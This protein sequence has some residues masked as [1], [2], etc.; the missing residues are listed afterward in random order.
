MKAP[1]AVRLAA[2]LVTPLLASTS[3]CGCGFDCNNG[4]NNN[5]SPALLSLGLSDSLPEDLKQ[6]VIEVDSITLQRSGAADVVIEQFTIDD[7]NGPASDTFQVDL[8]DYQG[9]NQLIVISDLELD[10][11][12]YSGISIAIVDEDINNSFVQEADDSIKILSAT[13]SAI[14]APGMT[15]DSGTQQFTVEFGLAQSLQYRSGD[16]SY[17][18]TNNGVR[19]EDN[20]VAASLS[21]RVDRDLFDSVSPCDEKTDPESGNRVYLYQGQGLTDGQLGDVFNSGSS[22]EVP[23]NTIAPFAVASMA[24][25]A[26]TGIWQYAFGFLPA[27]DYTLAFSCDTADDDSTDFDDLTIA[28]PTGQVYEISLGEAETAVC[29]LTTDA[30]CS[31]Q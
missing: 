4:N 29:D 7:P 19:T 14:S 23:D 5:D 6:V 22:A 13:G 8:L 2:I 25:D 9:R 17:L 1:L 16:D 31:A 28:L 30:N 26:L 12:T 18:L 27:D 15:L 21:G 24:E 3:G 11:D 10:S 20:A